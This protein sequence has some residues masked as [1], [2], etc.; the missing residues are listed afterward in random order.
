MTELLEYHYP[1]EFFEVGDIKK[2]I[3]RFPPENSGTLHLGHI[4]AMEIDFSFAKENGG[5]CILRFDDTNPNSECEEYY[6]A[7]REDVLWMGYDFCKETNTSDYFDILYEYAVKLI[8]NDNAYICELSSDELRRHRHEQ[9]PS[10]YRNRSVE[11]S[12]KLFEEMKNGLH[13]ENTMTLRMKGNLESTNTTLL[14]PVMYRI[15][16]KIHGKTKDKWII[17]PSYDYSHGIIDSI[18]GITHSFCTKEYEIRREQYYWFIEKLNM[19]APYVYEFGRMEVENGTLSKRNIRTMIENKIVSGWDDPRLLTIKG[20]RRRGYTQDALKEFCRNAGITKNE[21]TLSKMLLENIIRDKLNPIVFRKLAVFNPL[22]IIINNFESDIICEC[23]DFPFDKNSSKR[24]NILT[25]E[26]YIDSSNFKEIDE[27]DFYGLAPGKTIRIKYGPF[28]KFE[29]YDKQ[30]NVVYVNLT[31]PQNP[32]KIKGILNWVNNYYNEIIIR[33]FDE[34]I[35]NETICYIESNVN[36]NTV[37][38]EDKFQFEKYGYYC[39][40]KDTL[41]ND[42]LI[43]NEIVKLKSS[44]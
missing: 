37:Q 32:K 16:K 15:I 27:K 35:M 5:E 31:N 30:N 11:E 44:Y 8:T 22:R 10:P 24:I 17:Y 38:I 4:K 26:F 7:I 19:R 23:F 28:V 2:I 41:T 18:E 39:V 21:V 36:I 33:T 13:E 25:R 42:K 43:F 12:L 20:L 1:K 6:N 29:S 14:D 3:T 9:L 40:D 34:M